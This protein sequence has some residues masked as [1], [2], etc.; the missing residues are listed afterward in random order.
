[1]TFNQK[2]MAILCIGAIALGAVNHNPNDPFWQKFDGSK[3]V[4][5][6]GLGHA[7]E[8]LRPWQ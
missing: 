2:I 4:Q 7:Q 1:M 5:E 3:A 6:Q 8:G